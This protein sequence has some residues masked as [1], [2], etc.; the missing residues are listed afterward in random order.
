MSIVNGVKNC[1]AITD[2]LNGIIQDTG[3][4]I[5]IDNQELLSTGRHHRTAEKT[6]AR[7]LHGS[8]TSGSP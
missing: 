5:D 1:E 4:A 7:L 3:R 6:Q 8:A 2:L